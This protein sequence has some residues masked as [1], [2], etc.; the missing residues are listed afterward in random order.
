MDQEDRR[1]V[2]GENST[3]MKKVRFITITGTDDVSLDD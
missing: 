2:V 1:V 3:K